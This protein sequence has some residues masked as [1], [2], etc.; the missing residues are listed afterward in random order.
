MGAIGGL[1]GLN[2]GSSGSGYGNPERA[3]IV[4]PT[5]PDQISN[6]Y[7]GVQGSLQ[8]QN[9]LL[10][11]LQGQNG[12]SN[13]NQVYGQLQ[14]IANGTGP[15]PA[16]AMLNQA[17]GQNVA[18][19]AALMAGQ[20]GAGS[21]VGLIGRE[22]AQQGANTQQQAAGQAATLQ[23]NQSLNAIGQ[24]GNLAN[25]Q[26]A[27]Q[28]GQTNANTSAQQAE[29]QNLL[30]TQLGVNNANVASQGNIN[31]ANSSM[32]NTTMQG[33]QGLLGGLLNAAGV[34]VGK[35]QGGEIVKYADGGDASAFQGP[36][37]KF[38]QFLSGVQSGGPQSP[39]MSPGG[40]SNEGSRELSKG[41]TSASKGIAKAADTAG[42]ASMARGGDAKN[43]TAG[44]KVNASGSKQKAVARG[45]S[46]SNDKIPALLSE[47]EI[48]L[49]REVTMSK[50]PV[51]ESAKFVAAVIAKRRMGKR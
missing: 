37:S 34:G 26:A 38:G 33:Q 17:T 42:S 45:N 30:N 47:H 11:A 14:G 2:G 27:N 4:N 46:Y 3:N 51:G 22:A 24:A 39:A 13:Q 49:P 35:A 29:Q 32:A 6:A 43:M 10:A 9:A 23:A 50:D 19:Q 1:L 12:L 7:T 44:G 41:V 8:G 18:N 36:Q 5:S 28:I 20:R 16:Q 21:N 25:T 48:V 31:N 15:N 40:G